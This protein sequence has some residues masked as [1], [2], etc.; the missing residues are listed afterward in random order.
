ME[1]NVV[2]SYKE[3]LIDETI[4]KYLNVFGGIVIEG[5]KWCG[6]TWTSLKHAKRCPSFSTPC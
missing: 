4:D 5:P 3:R 2:K 6:K 1:N